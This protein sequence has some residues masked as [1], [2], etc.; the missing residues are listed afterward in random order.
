MQ[1]FD[2]LDELYSIE[3]E[4]G[5]M[6]MEEGLISMMISNKYADAEIYL[7]GAHVTSFKPYNS[8]EL[9]WMSPESNF[10]PG[11]AIRG[12]I[13]LCFPWFGPAKEEG[14]PQHGFGRLMTW[15]V[16]EVKTLPNGE[17]FICLQL[18]SSEETKKYWPHDF[19]AELLI[20]VGRKLTA[21]LKVTNTSE[22]EFDYTCALHTY[23][24]VSNIAHISINGLQGTKYRNSFA[25]EV[26]TQEEEILQINKEEN[27]YYFDTE[28]TCLIEDLAVKR[29]IVAEKSGSK[30][31][32]VWNPGAESCAKMSDVPDEGYKNFVCVEGVN[33]FD[34]VIKLA[35]Q[36]SH[37]TSVTLGLQERL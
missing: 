20:T 4:V 22:I 29:T 19:C 10:E 26:F 28:S 15:D 6:E 12:G 31:T 27:R 16:S 13:P 5:F 9:L 3:G 1:T 32:V 2:Q 18:Y 36:Q 24:L 7:Q 8:L 33:T 21:N 17:T 30:V 37:E 34:D 23:Y 14:L 25:P 35:P 11:K